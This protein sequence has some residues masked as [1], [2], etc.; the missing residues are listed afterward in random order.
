MHARVPR[1]AAALISLACTCLSQEQL[2]FH[3][4]TKLVTVPFQV[5]RGSRSVDLNPSDVVLLEDGVPRSFAVFEKP[6]EHLTLDLVVMF[7]V[8]NPTPAPAA[9]D[10]K[11]TPGFWDTKTLQD[12]AAF[13]SGAIA[14][15]LLEAPG[16]SVRF[17]IYRLDQFR[18]Q[19]LC[20]S[21][22]DPAVLA[23]ALYRLA[24]PAPAG[25]DDVPFPPGLVI[26]NMERKAQANGYPPQPWSLAAAILTL[27]DSA[28][29]SPS[30]EQPANA[31]APAASRALVIFS[32]G[33]EGTTVTPDDLADQAINAGVPVYPVAL[34]AFP[35]VL[36]Y[37]GYT[38]ATP[39]PNGFFYFYPSKDE[40]EGGAKA[41]MVGPAGAQYVKNGAAC[42]NCGAP[43]YA[44]YYNYP[45]ELLGEVT[46]GI[47]FDAMNRFT[48]SA[49]DTPG[50][51]LLLHRDGYSMTGAETLNILERVKSHALA[52]FSSS[53]TLGF[54]PAPS[55][56][57]R[58]HKLEVKLAPKISGK[59][60]EGQRNATY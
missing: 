54:V 12:L 57:P 35:S 31:G 5:R 2:T 27:K 56:S 42:S 59:V 52:R 11:A 43:Y 34:P 29:A 14:R 45:F 9:K 55:E 53:Y 20:R 38:Y 47:R 22:A 18:L 51:L 6:P 49:L 4:Q 13:W 23:G 58:R 36:P 48:A 10:G 37:E 50:L 3:A 25:Q 15:R 30:G 46:G 19:R 41:L 24:G 33:A 26:R 40:G 8:T 32:T 44:S 28:A 17:S 60:I 21:T 39:V 1:I 16:V 7:D